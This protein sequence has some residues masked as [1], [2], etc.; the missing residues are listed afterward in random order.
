MSAFADLDE[1]INRLTGGNDG[2][3]VHLPFYRD[4]RVGAAVAAATVAGRLTSLWQY[5]GQPSH[6]AAPGAVAA[7]TRATA[8]ALAQAN[9]GG[10][11]QLWLAGGWASGF[12][13]GTLILYDRLLHISGLSGTV[14]TP[15]AVGGTLTR[16]TGGLGNE[17][18][19]EI[20]TQIGAT[21]TTIT[22]EY[23]DQDGNDNQV[24][25]STAFGGTAFREAQRIIK[26]PLASGDNGVQEVESVTLAGT[27]GTAGDFGVTVARPLLV[28]PLPAAGIGNVRDL[29]AQQPGL[30]EI[31]TDACLALAYHANNVTAPQIF[32]GLQLVER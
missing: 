22:A 32:G 18:W 14:T 24:T 4:A 1:L 27:T 20:Y 26:M 17:L 19:L 25:Q 7:P 12:S 30:Q 29:V 8:G 5:N 21:P 3:P 31:D 13:T 16:N 10:G 28:I 11:R 2:N 15:Q 6:G 23:T 9:P